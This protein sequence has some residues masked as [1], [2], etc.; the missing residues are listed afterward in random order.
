[1]GVRMMSQNGRA[2]VWRQSLSR[3]NLTS[4]TRRPLEST[5]RRFKEPLRPSLP[6]R[7][8]YCRESKILRKLSKPP[9]CQLEMQFQIVQEQPQHQGRLLSP[10][11]LQW[12]QVHDMRN[13]TF[14]SVG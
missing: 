2:V 6:I 11:M 5:C 1:M 13:A 7:K 4:R 10:P 14:D 9:R 12:Q 8:S 3:G